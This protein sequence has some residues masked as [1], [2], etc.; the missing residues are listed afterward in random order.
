MNGDD[1]SAS[2]ARRAID[3]VRGARQDFLAVCEAL[4]ELVNAL[5]PHV[6][7]LDDVDPI[8][9]VVA[10]HAADLDENARRRV[11]AE[12]RDVARGIKSAF[13]GAQGDED[14]SSLEEGS[15]QGGGDD[16]KARVEI[17]EERREISVTVSPPAASAVMALIRSEIAPKRLGI[18]NRSLVTMAVA[19]F[20]VFVGQLVAACLRKHP[21]IL[22]TDAKEFALDD[23]QRFERIQDATE[24]LISRRVESL[25]SGGLDAW[26]KWFRDRPLQIEF[27]A[28]ALSWGET[29]ELFQRRHIIVHHG[30]RVSRR[31]LQKTPDM[32]TSPPS[33]GSLLEP[34]ADYVARSVDLVL[35]LGTLVSSRL[36]TKLL[37][38]SAVS[39]EA[40]VLADLVYELLQAGR[41][42]AA[43]A[44]AK[45]GEEL[46]KILESSESTRLRFRCNA[47]LCRKRL[48]GIDSIRDEVEAWDTS[49]LSG[50]FPLV[51]AALL[52]QVDLA[53]ELLPAALESEEISL[54]D[55]REWPILEELRAD[56]RFA[57]Y[58]Q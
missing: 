27:E 20:E 5:S 50:V 39:T 24:E 7:A 32:G 17:D 31:Y 2:E 30:G 56:T 26:E 41:W 33:L 29:Q 19:T 22:G 36:L 23:L 28:N 13:E 1:Q 54:G 49:A 43:G 40:P 58:D 52:D 15:K 34:D 12:L 35:V 4:L 9:T 10:K 38:P 47:W 3:D 14:P 37:P 16:S 18:L 21:G 55:L 42:D 48:D 57:E 46:S 8:G 45:A 6:E 51:Q 11:A 25:M 53:Y 44:V